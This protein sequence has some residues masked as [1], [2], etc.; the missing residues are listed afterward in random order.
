MK[1][2]MRFI[3][4]GLILISIQNNAQAI[5]NSNTL[6]LDLALK[7]AQEA[8]RF[9]E[10]SGYHITATV[11]DMSGQI[12]VQLKGDQSTIHT[13]DTAFRKAYT[14]VTLG[15]VFKLD[16]STQVAVLMR[17]NPNRAAFLTVPEIT[18]LP[19]A[20][21]IKIKNKIVAAIGVGGA[22]GGAKDEAC[23]Q[24]GATKINKLSLAMTLMFIS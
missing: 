8:I 21:A 13:K 11:V 15:P 17:N 7:A 5:E 23:A 10:A 4:S 9:C 22:P 1:K 12:K 24:A 20:V 6:P 19:G 18:P 3:F 2:Y 14:V 16:T